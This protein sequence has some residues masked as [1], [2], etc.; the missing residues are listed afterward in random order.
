MVRCTDILFNGV[1]WCIVPIGGLYATYHLLKE[2]GN[3][4]DI[5]GTIYDHMIFSLQFFFKNIHFV[6]F[7]QGGCKI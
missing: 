3:S 7:V 2:P 5:V 6:C 1:S 4:I